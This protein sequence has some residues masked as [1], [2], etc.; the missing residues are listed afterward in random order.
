LKTLIDKQVEQNKGKIYACF[1][2][3]KKAFDSIWHE[4][5]FLKLLENKI[6]GQFYSLIK[7]LYSNSKCAIKQNN[8]RTDF[9]T[10]SN[11]VRQGCILSPL[12]FN[13]Y[14]NEI[15]TLFKNT[16]S[17]PFILPNGTEL[18]CL[19]YADDLIIYLNQNSASRSVWINSIAG[20]R[21]G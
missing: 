5:L 1:V 20:V 3:F 9:F 14:I 8:I 17:D 4:G 7:S 11:G 21:S 13:I 12:L 18:S 15:T 19:L 6:D 16:N 2:D 10:Y